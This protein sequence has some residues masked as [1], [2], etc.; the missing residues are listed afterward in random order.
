MAINKDETQYSLFG[1]FVKGRLFLVINLALI[2][3]HG[4][5]LGDSLF[6]NIYMPVGLFCERII[7]ITL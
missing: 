6:G 5:E 2:R 3:L 1:L 7:V 4:Y